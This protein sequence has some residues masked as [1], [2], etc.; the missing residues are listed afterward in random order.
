MDKQISIDIVASTISEVRAYC[1]PLTDCG[2]CIA[3]INRNVNGD[4]TAAIMIDS[5]LSDVQHDT[6]IDFLKRHEQT[7]DLAYIV[8][9]YDAL[10]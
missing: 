3:S 7:D 9:L 6:L 10:A 8:D 4:F 5:S 2:I 1:K